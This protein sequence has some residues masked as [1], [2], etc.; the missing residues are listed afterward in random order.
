MRPSTHSV[1]P[2]YNHL[3]IPMC[4]YTVFYRLCPFFPTV[5]LLVP[6]CLLPGISNL[7]K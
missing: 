7:W 4:P 6:F 2:P 1:C 5:S 3:A